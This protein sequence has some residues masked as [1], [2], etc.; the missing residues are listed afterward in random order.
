MADQPQ[1]GF[2]EGR[3]IRLLP[4][5]G[6]LGGFALGNVPDKFGGPPNLT[7][8]AITNGKTENFDPFGG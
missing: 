7:G 5:E 6:L 8:L 4:L 1:G 2:V 3:E